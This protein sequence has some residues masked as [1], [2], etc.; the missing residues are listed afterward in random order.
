MFSFICFIL[1]VVSLIMVIADFHWGWLVALV[2]T[3][4]YFLIRLG[5]GH[6]TVDI[7]ID[8]FD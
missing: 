8:L 2:L 1:W 6:G 3:T 4:L 7:D 5:G